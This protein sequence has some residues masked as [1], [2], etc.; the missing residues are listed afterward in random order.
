VT[1]DTSEG[2][3]ETR[4]VESLIHEAGYLPGRNE[5]YERV[6]AA[7]P[8][9]DTA[10]ITGNGR[11][12]GGGLYKMEPKE[13]GNIPAEFLLIAIGLNTGRVQGR[14]FDGVEMGE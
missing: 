4:I 11:V 6:F 10:S 5:D 8:S 3:L 12:Y 1:T 9:V 2:G 7:L 14:L 13:L